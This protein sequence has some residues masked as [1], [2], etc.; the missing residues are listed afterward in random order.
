MPET[1]PESLNSKRLKLERS[2]TL[3]QHLETFCKPVGFKASAPL[4]DKS[5]GAK[6]LHSETSATSKALLKVG[7]AVARYAAS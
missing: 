2:Q 3:S 7:Q 1:R 5:N 4:K 6:L